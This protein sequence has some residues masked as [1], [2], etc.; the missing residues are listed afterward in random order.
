MKIKERVYRGG[1]I[2]FNNEIGIYELIGC[3]LITRSKIGSDRVEYI[4]KQVRIHAGSKQSCIG[5]EKT[6]FPENH[7]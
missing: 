7:F 2:R 4:E 1:F 5:L 6:M 3:E